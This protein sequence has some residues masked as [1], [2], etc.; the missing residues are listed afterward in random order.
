MRERRNRNRSGKAHRGGKAIR[1]RKDMIECPNCGATCIHRDEGSPPRPSRARHRIMVI[2]GAAVLA[3]VA[4]AALASHILLSEPPKYS[5]TLSIQVYLEGRASGATVNL[6]VYID[7]QLAREVDL[8]EDYYGWT[9]NVTWRNQ[10]THDCH[11]VVF[12]DGQKWPSLYQDSTNRLE[13]GGRWLAEVH[14]RLG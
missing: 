2:L 9:F 5:A 10:T 13:D 6:S 12:C 11:L 8:S 14:I 3:G 4:I 7:G 1:V